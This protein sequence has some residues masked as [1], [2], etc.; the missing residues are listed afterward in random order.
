MGHCEAEMHQTE[1][2]A[3]HSGRKFIQAPGGEQWHKEFVISLY[4]KGKTN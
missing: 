4:V 3:L 1:L 2:K